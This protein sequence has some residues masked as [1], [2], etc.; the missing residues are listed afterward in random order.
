MSRDKWE[1]ACKGLGT[2]CAICGIALPEEDE[3]PRP[4]PDLNPDVS[5][6]E[7]K[8]NAPFDYD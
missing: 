8:E 7:T 1:R 2:A 3:A 5:L 6:A 4:C